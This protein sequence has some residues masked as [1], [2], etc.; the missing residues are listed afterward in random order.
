[1]RTLFDSG[2]GAAASEDAKRQ[3]HP[4]RQTVRHSLSLRPET[5]ECLFHSGVY[6]TL[7]HTFPDRLEAFRS[8]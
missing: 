1:M 2:S 8:E 5:R 7:S 3:S 4:L 6:V